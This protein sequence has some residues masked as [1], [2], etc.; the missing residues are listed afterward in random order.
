M[1]YVPAA[2]LPN[3]YTPLALLIAVLSPL[4]KTPF[5]L[6]SMYILRFESSVSPESNVPFLLL[7]LK[8][9]PETEPGVEVV[10]CSTPKFLPE[11]TLEP[12]ETS[13]TPPAGAV[14]WKLLGGI[15]RTRYVPDVRL[16]NL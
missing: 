9:L 3:V 4:S 2:R 15:T 14:T 16:L 13:E 7:S 10:F 5:L 11:T 8:T 6:A 12:T 1:R